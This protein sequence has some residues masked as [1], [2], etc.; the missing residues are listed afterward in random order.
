MNQA[1]EVMKSFIEFM[2]S[3]QIITYYVSYM[4]TKG[5]KPKESFHP[6]YDNNKATT[7]YFSFDVNYILFYYNILQPQ[8][9]KVAIF[10]VF[11]YF[12]YLRN[13]TVL[14]GLATIG[15]ELSIPGR[16]GGFQSV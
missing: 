13:G 15:F 8:H 5:R 3:V 4:S 1:M 2:N 12:C 16:A 9:R 6:Q 7:Y 14:P 11:H 10:T